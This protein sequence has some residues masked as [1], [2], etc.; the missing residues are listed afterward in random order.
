MW[1]QFGRINAGQLGLKSDTHRGLTIQFLRCTGPRRHK[2][3]RWYVVR[4]PCFTNL[5]YQ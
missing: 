2:L 4:P 1:F 3:I 5:K